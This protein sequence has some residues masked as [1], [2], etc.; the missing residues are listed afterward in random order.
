MG[1]EVTLTIDD[2]GKVASIAGHKCKEGQKYVLDEYKNPV[3]TLTATVLTQSSS[4]SLLAVRTTAPIPKAKLVPGMI[5][6]AKVRTKPPIKIGD[7]IT[8]NLLDTG[9][10]VVATS[11]LPF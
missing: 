10:D 3:R 2:D 6:L 5:A 8:S 4:Q 9:I 11:D 7:V 1:C